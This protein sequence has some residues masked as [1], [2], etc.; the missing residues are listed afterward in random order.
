MVVSWD[1]AIAGKQTVKILFYGINIDI[2]I[3]H[4]D[5]ESS[6]KFRSILV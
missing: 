1:M 5:E 2:L 3:I 6:K 4:I